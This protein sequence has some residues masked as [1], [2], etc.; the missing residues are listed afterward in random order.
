[1]ALDGVSWVQGGL[2]E[3]A[4]AA[5][6]LAVRQNRRRPLLPPSGHA[7]GHP[8]LGEA[9]TEP[10]RQSDPKRHRQSSYLIFEGDALADQLLARD[11]ER[12]D[13]M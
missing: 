13:G 9:R 6:G 8:L 12:A 7:G 5:R 11:E 1:M 3:T 2:V 4:L 10:A